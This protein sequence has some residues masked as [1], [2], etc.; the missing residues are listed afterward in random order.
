MVFGSS[1]ST[2]ICLP[3]GALSVVVR[4]ICAPLKKT[5]TSLILEEAS[6]VSLTQNAVLEIKRENS[7]VRNFIIKR[8]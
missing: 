5:V 3:F 7:K 8:I 6:S 4:V 1:F 2:R